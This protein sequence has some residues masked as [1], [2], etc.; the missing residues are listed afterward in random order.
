MTIKKYQEPGFENI[1]NKPTPA[2]DGI[3]HDV[4]KLLAAG[5]AKFI[6][7]ACRALKQD[8]IPDMKESV[9]KQNPALQEAMRDKLLD[10]F[11]KER[12]IDGVWS[13]NSIEP[14]FEDFLLYAQYQEGNSTEKGKEAVRIREAKKYRRKLQEQHIDQNLDRII[15]KSPEP[16]KEAE[17]ITTTTEGS[18]K[19]TT[20]KTTTDY[21]PKDKE[22]PEPNQL[23]EDGIKT[24]TKIFELLTGIDKKEITFS[25]NT[26]VFVEHIKPSRDFRLRL[27]KGIEPEQVIHYQR[28]LM[29]VDKLIQDALK[30][31][32]DISRENKEEITK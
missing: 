17:E 12:S 10:V 16:P 9:L 3:A 23:Y 27:F 7:E 26:D 5:V 29:W 31:G 11:A 18:E 32:L 15:S 24:F 2:L 22:L 19:F 20:G 28:A 4:K 30:Q 8:W 1:F 6:P 21:S 13:E 14:N 25:P